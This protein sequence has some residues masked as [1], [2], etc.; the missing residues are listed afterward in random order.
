MLGA[1]GHPFVAY[2]DGHKLA[3]ARPY[4]VRF[5]VKTPTAEEPPPPVPMPLAVGDFT[6]DGIED[7]VFSDFLLASGR[8]PGTPAPI[9]YPFFPGL[10]APWTV[11]RIADLNGNG[12]PDVVAASRGGFG[13][14]FFNGTGTLNLL[15]FNLPTNGPVLHLE[16]G[17][18]T[19]I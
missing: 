18:W 12:K 5:N 1:Q 16:A 19:A 7:F 2:G 9:Y 8:T 15:P 6:G 17:D 13:I 4:Q 11:A 10:P 3:P 14:D